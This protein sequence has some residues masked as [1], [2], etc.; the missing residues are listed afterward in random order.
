M[1]F[2]ILLLPWLELFTLIQLGVATS[3]VTA[4]FYVLVTLVL[5]LAILRR[6][7]AAMLQRMQDNQGVSFLGPELLLDEMAMGFAGLLLVFP[8]LITDAVAVIVLVGPLRRRLVRAFK[9][10][11]PEPFVHGREA[12]YH[13]TIEGT[14]RRIDED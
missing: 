1:R 3:A 12:H 7:G 4:L 2:L 5:G 14:F 8:G 13:E 11:E 6:Q 9:G 10:P